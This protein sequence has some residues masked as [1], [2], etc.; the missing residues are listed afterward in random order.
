M[1]DHISVTVGD[2]DRSRAVHDGTLTPL[3][4]QHIAFVAPDRP[5][6]DAFNASALAADGRDNGASVLRP[7]DF[8]NDYAA[9]VIDP[10]G[11][12]IEAVCHKPE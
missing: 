2:L 12:H 9:S 1:I 3:V 7:A 5:S 10:D 6:V 11:H 4:G 8:P